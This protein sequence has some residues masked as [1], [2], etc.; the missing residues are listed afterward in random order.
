MGCLGCREFGCSRHGSAGTFI[1][2][3]ATTTCL[4]PLLFLSSKTFLSPDCV[5]TT[6]KRKKKARLAVAEADEIPLCFVGTCTK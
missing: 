2:L 4:N 3:P 1:L 5:A 6:I